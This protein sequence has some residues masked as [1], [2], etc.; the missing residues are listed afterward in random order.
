MAQRDY[1]YDSSTSGRA[2][3]RDSNRDMD[4][5]WSRNGDGRIRGTSG[6][7]EYYRGGRND[8]W[9]GYSER[10]R[11]MG[12]DSSGYRNSSEDFDRG[13]YS[14][15]RGREEETF[16]RGSESDS[17]WNRGQSGRS[18]QGG[19]RDNWEF[20]RGDRGYSR[21]S[22]DQSRYGSMSR[23]DGAYRGSS[24]WD[25][26]GRGSRSEMESNYSRSFSPG[27]GGGTYNERGSGYDGNG[28]SFRSYGNRD[29]Y[30]DRGRSEGR[31][32][33][34]NY[35]MNPNREGSRGDSYRDAG[36]RDRRS[37]YE[38]DRESARGGGRSR[39]TRDF[40]EDEAW[41]DRAS[42]RRNS[43]GN[44]REY[45]YSSP[46]GYGRGRSSFGSWGS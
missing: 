9:S 23:A 24:D 10:D 22:S 36:S 14:S 1:D 32:G 6:Q 41:A 11:S 8:D 18:Y 46:T 33:E 5:E 28:Y 29:T 35:G 21:E 39:Y 19:Y 20:D 4:R 37:S 2:S 44:D 34:S 27:H 45:E 43:M 26:R 30:S 17:D 15:N 13:R 12:S 7:G 25:D 42:S 16:R 40:E 3:R 38:D 31:Y